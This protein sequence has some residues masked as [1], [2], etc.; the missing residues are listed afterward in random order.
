MRAL[1]ILLL[2]AAFLGASA[3]DRADADSSELA[4]HVMRLEGFDFP[5]SARYDP[6]QD[7]FFI[8]NILGYGSVKDGEAYIARVDAGD[9][10]RPEV[11]IRSGRGGAVLD[12]PKGMAIQGDTLWVA[13]ID[14]VRGFDR[15]TGAPVANIDMTPHDIVMLNDITTGPD[16]A[17]YVTD[18]GIVMSRVGVA[19]YKGSKIFRIAPG[20]QV[21]VF[22]QSEALAH[23]NGITWDSAGKQF[24]VVTFHPSQSELYSIGP[25]NK[26]NVMVTGLGRYDGVESLHD[27]RIVLTSWSDSSVQMVQGG[28]T[29]RIINNVWQP[30][31]LGVDTRRNRLAIPLVLQGRVEIYQ[32]PN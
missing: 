12:A 32:L 2:G 23:P 22:A 9:L 10:R 18:T 19:Y 8:S 3:C 6:Q 28:K 4:R 1:R 26:K 14:Q 25:N 17:L 7:V 16:G 20:R 15:R 5:E 29:H 24:V 13:D 31:D 21:T 30:A 27:G 11:F